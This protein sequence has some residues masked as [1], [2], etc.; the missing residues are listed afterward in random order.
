MNTLTETQIAL[1]RESYAMTMRQSG[2]FATTFYH[3][4]FQQHP[5]VRA[6]FSDDIAA[7][8]HALTAT[9]GVVVASLDDLEP[10]LPAL[11]ALARRH[12][13]YGTRP[14]H[15]PIIGAVLVNAFAE[16]LHDHFTPNA[17][18]AWEAAYAILS[19]HMIEA[20]YGTVS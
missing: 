1:I 17:R 13:G 20:A 19:A 8:E 6:L 2:G 16:V 5:F 12:V 3:R 9:L 10:M 7:Q 18:T 14:A 4:L 15:Y 11:R